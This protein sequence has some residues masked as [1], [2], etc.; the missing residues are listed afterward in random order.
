MATAGEERATRQQI[1]G[2]KK[3][4]GIRRE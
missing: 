2:L 4:C 3:V 1:A